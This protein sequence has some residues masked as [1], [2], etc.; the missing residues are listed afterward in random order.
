MCKINYFPTKQ[1]RK[2]NF[3]VKYR[4]FYVFFFTFILYNEHFKLALKVRN[5]Y[6]DRNIMQTT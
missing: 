4:Q 3:S 5:D 2:I 1:R 6:I